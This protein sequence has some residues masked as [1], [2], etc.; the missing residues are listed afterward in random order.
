MVGWFIVWLL[1]WLNMTEWLQWLYI[2]YA[3]WQC[4]GKG[5]EIRSRLMM[6]DVLSRW[7]ETWGER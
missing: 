1:N 7:P 5:S 6:E 4:F 3:I 2:V